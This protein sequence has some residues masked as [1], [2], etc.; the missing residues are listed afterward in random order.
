MKDF[1]SFKTQAATA[2]I[3]IKDPN[4][5]ALVLEGL[6]LGHPEIMRKFNITIKQSELEKQAK[7]EKVFSG[8]DTQQTCTFDF[9]ELAPE[10]FQ[11][12]RKIQN[13]DDKLIKKI[14]SFDNIQKLNVDV[15]STKG[16]SFYIKPEQGGL[17]VTSITRASYRMIQQFLPDY[18]RYLL[19]NPNTYITPIVGVYTLNITRGGHNLPVYF[20]LQRNILGFDPKTL[21]TDDLTF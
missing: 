6:V 5:E 4:A 21:E 20:I 19:M 13:I 10:V 15:S 17:I 18:Y 7:T 2:Q 14:F 1:F 8:T 9:I 16:G 3:S 12:I 11:T